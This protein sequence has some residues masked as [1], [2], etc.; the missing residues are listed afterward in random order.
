MESLEK[1]GRQY[2]Y[3]S[4]A[5]LFGMMCTKFSQNRTMFGKDIQKRILV[6]FLNT[7]YSANC[8]CLIKHSIAS[9]TRI[10]IRPRLH[11][12]ETGRI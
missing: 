3:H 12:S 6:F 2:L 10:A 8:L 11:Y 9:S 4:K 1:R 5:N 7:V